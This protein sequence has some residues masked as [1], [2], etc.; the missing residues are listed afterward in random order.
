MKSLFTKFQPTNKNTR[1]QCIIQTITSQLTQEHKITTY[2]TNNYFSTYRHQFIIT[3]T[4]NHPVRKITNFSVWIW[5][6]YCTLIFQAPI[7][8]SEFSTS[9]VSLTTLQSTSCSSSKPGLPPLLWRINGDQPDCS[10]NWTMCNFNLPSPSKLI[11]NQWSPNLLTGHLLPTSC[12]KLRSICWSWRIRAMSL[13][14]Q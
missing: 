7:L 9:E 5:V 14:N 6:W 13:T 11:K 12:T 1:L 8:L 4:P 3:E 10:D 2:H